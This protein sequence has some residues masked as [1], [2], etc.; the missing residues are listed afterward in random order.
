VKEKKKTQIFFLFVFCLVFLFCFLFLL[1][2]MCG[3]LLRIFCFVFMVLLCFLLFT[4]WLKIEV[5]SLREKKAIAFGL[6]DTKYIHLNSTDKSNEEKGLKRQNWRLTQKETWKIDEG[7]SSCPNAFD[8]LFCFYVFVNLWIFLLF[9]CFMAFYGF[10]LLFFCLGFSCFL[11]F[12]DI[13][14]FLC[15]CVFVFWCFMAFYVFV[16]VV[17]ARQQEISV[18]QQRSLWYKIIIEDKRRWRVAQS[19]GLGA[20]VGCQLYKALNT[21]Q[22]RRSNI[23]NMHY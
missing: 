12:S 22:P 21:S 13:F 3:F 4:F 14:L 9:L 8:F 2:W 19:W 10:V 18:V 6:E 17:N 23:L 1:L 20:E 11:V 5:C 7:R 16:F 15:F